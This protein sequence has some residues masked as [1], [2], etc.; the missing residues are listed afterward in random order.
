MVGIL[1]PIVFIVVGIP[2]LTFVPQQ[3]C[4]NLGRHREKIT[5]AVATWMS[6]VPEVRMDQMVGKVNG[7]C[8]ISPTYKWDIVGLQPFHLLMS[9]IY[10]GKETH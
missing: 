2:G 1:T 3:G 9:E 6:R 7:L 10:W 8:H 5:M 4:E